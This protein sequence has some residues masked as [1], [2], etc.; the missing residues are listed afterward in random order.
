MK[1]YAAI[2]FEY[3]SDID[4]GQGVCIAYIVYNIH[5]GEAVASFTG[6]P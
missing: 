1:S 4:I 3:R 6:F 5:Y 2:S